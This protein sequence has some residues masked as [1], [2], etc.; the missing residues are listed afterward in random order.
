MTDLPD[1][2]AARSSRA[3]FLPILALAVALLGVALG[4]SA[5]FVAAGD[6]DTVKLPAAMTEHMATMDEHMGDMGRM[7]MMGSADVDAM[8][9]RCTTMMGE[10]HGMDDAA[11]FCDSMLESMP[12]VSSSMM[13]P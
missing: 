8:R 9:D 7:G 10:L 6:D 5:I 11:A 2:S 1:T 12:M 4:A 3:P 13:H